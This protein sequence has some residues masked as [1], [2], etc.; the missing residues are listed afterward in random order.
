MHLSLLLLASILILLARS[1]KFLV[2]TKQGSHFMASTKNTSNPSP[3][4]FLQESGA[5]YFGAG[6]LNKCSW[7]QSG[8]MV[9]HDIPSQG[10]S[11]HMKCSGGCLSIH[12]V[13]YA[14]KMAPTKKAQLKAVQK[15]CQGKEE[16]NVKPGE[17]LFGKVTCK[18]STK[19]PLMWIVYSCDSGTDETTT[20]IPGDGGGVEPGKCLDEQGQ[21]K[22]EDI[23]GIVGWVDLRCPGGCLT[24]HK[25]LYACQAAGPD[26]IQ[27]EIVRKLCQG[28]E[29]CFIQPGPKVF[30]KNI[31]CP[32]RNTFPLM[33]LHYS[34]AGGKDETKTFIPDDPK[35]HGSYKC[36]KD[37]TCKNQAGTCR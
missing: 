17:K 16:C 37:S 30:E 21:M 10:G 24:I 9:Q 28:K 33:W 31:V 14:C 4:G 25:V 35:C 11:I 18:E 15:L 1:D 5:D 7:K 29:S 6:W 23:P 22:Q 20:N 2:K 3:P 36:S 32:G 26:K 34:C 12:K 13:L 27:L 8:K 19:T